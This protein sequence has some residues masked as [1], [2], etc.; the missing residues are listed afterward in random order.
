MRGERRRKEGGEKRRDETIDKM[1]I[2]YITMEWQAYHC[3]DVH[4]PMSGVGAL[5]DGHD[6]E[7]RSKIC[8]SFHLRA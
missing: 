2:R 7:H 1:G 5:D 6:T 3:P 8:Y 4:S